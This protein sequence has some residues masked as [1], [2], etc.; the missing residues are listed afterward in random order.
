MSGGCVVLLVD[1]QAIVAAALRQML[2]S[3]GD[4]EFH[5]CGDPERAVGDALKLRPTVILQ[6][7]VMPGIDGFALL[8]RYRATAA[9]DAVP[10][11]ILSSQEDPNDKSRAFASGANDYLVKIPDRIELVAR[12][13]AYSQAY[14][15]RAERDAAYRA[16]EE[17]KLQLEQKN[18]I[19]L[20]LSELDGLTGIA[21]RRRF[22]QALDVEWRRC[23]REGSELGLILIDVDF[24]K[25]YNDSYG[26]LMG[27]EVLRRVAAALG[28]ALRR[29]SDLVARFGGEEFGVLLPATDA[30]EA[31][32]TAEK[33]RET[34]YGLAIPHARSEID[35]RVTISLG[36]AS[37]APTAEVRTGDLV[38]LADEA[39]YGAKRGGRNRTATAAAR[40]RA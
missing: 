39:L 16:L 9:L 34:V 15:V 14:R 4:V 24:F 8:G 36:I 33:L 5:Y 13:R 35:A 22:D 30:A 3:E 37:V 18:A 12:I 21:N 26:H 7:L 20:E 38:A 40:V 11:I 23:H 1:D 28:Q 32:A 29:S 2:E 17:L 31:A 10:V 6:D 27:D 25:R 19:L